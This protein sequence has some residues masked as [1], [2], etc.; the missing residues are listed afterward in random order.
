MRKI[1]NLL[2]LT[3]LLSFVAVSCHKHE[4]DENAPVIVITAP[5][6]DVSISGIVAIAGLV[7]DESLHELSIK[8]TKDSDNS[9]LFSAAPEVHDLTS[10]AIAEVWTPTAIAAETAV[11]LTVIASDH[12]DHSVTSTVKF[13]V[14]P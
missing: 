1:Q 6:A 7:T 13:K 4:D 9:V 5:V 2:L 12:N 14:K 10:Y 8:V 3:L 11:T